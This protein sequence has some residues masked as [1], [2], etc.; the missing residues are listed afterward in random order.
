MTA[1][2]PEIN[3]LF[4]SCEERTRWGHEQLTSI[5]FEL[6]YLGFCVFKA[7]TLTTTV[8]RHCFANIA[9]GM[10]REL[11]CDVRLVR[12]YSMWMAVRMSS[13]PRPPFPCLPACL[14]A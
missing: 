13:P 12:G 6:A 10:P 14:L 2:L 4:L 7:T 1:F 3:S 5:E 9:S 8:D 11:Q